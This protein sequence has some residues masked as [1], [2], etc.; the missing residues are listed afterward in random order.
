[1]SY[2]QRSRFQTGSTLVYQ[3]PGSSLDL[4][5]E[6]QGKRK[7][8]AQPG[9]PK[10]E[11]PLFDAS[12]INQ[13]YDYVLPWRPDCHGEVTLRQDL[14]PRRMQQVEIKEVPI[15]RQERRSYAVWCSACQNIHYMAGIASSTFNIG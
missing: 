3:R 5:E 7:Q 14:E 13:F 10:H 1:M 11:H 6:G 8:G 12:Q 15:W 2:P 4:V 9:H